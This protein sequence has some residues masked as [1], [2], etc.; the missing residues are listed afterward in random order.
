M[1][2]FLN[3]CSN[4]GT[5]LRFGQIEGEDRDRL[6]CPEC[7]HIAYVNPRLVVT[8]FPITEDGEIVLLRRGIE[9]GRGQ[10]AQPGGFLEIDE[11]VNQAAIRE[12]WEETGLLIEPTEIVG[13]YTRLEAAVVTIAFSARIVGGTAAPTAEALEI[14]TFAPGGHPVVR[15]RVPDDDVGTPRLAGHAPAGCPVA[16]RRSGPLARKPGR[17][18]SPIRRVRATVRG[19]STSGRWHRAMTPVSAPDAGPMKRPDLDRPEHDL[20]GPAVRVVRHDLHDRRPRRTRIGQRQRDDEG[21]SRAPVAIS[22]SGHRSARAHDDGLRA[23]GLQ[24]DLD[25]PRRFAH[26]TAD[27]QVTRRDDL[28]GAC[29]RGHGHVREGRIER[30]DGRGRLDIRACGRTDRGSRG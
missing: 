10:W 11:T 5:S 13:L 16:G 14:R 20:L 26:V 18:S 27:H 12:T 9:P 17:L 30:R 23:P 22:R 25:A 21:S 6:S 7:G 8:V 3:F 28:V 29:R 1:A 4:C 19:G 24:H 15:P 2:Q